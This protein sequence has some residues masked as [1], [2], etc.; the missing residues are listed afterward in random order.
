MALKNPW[1]GYVDRSFEQIKSSLLSRL[2]IS[3]PE[4][5]D[6]SESNILVVIVSMFAGLTEMLGYYIDNMARESFISTARRYVS[7][8]KLVRLLDYRIKTAYPATVDITF[9]FDAALT[10]NAIIPQNTI[11]QTSNG[12]IF[13]TE[14]NL[15]ELI[16]E[17]LRA[18]LAAEIFEESNFE[19]EKYLL[20][21]HPN[22]SKQGLKLSDGVTGN[23]SVF[24]TEES[25]FETWSDNKSPSIEGL[26]L[27]LSFIKPCL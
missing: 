24:G 16:F 7:M 10:A 17:Q 20:L 2:T 27:L 5:T 4:I 18:D 22:Q 21:L 26:F 1:V 9:T 12:I 13:Y 3:N 19:D 23:T 6:H 8:V 11:V 15:K 25:R 14:A